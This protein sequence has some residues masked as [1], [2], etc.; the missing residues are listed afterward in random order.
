MTESEAV[1]L[2]R[3]YM[4]DNYGEPTDWLH[5]KPTHKVSISTS[6]RGD[7]YYIVEFEGDSSLEIWINT[8]TKEVHEQTYI[9]DGPGPNG[10]PT[11]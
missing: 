2:A 7:E 3:V 8:K 11:V 9:F 10:E 5:R 6:E 1:D 4:H